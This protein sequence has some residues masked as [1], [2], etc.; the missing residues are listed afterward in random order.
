MIDPGVEGEA[1]T[2]EPVQAGQEEA[3]GERWASRLVMFL[4]LMAVVALVL[5]FFTKPV[6]YLPHCVLG[7][8]VFMIAIRLINLRSLADIRP[9]SPGEFALAITTASVV[10]VA[11]V[12]QGILLAIV[13]SLLRVVQHNY[14][15][16][17]GVGPQFK[18]GKHMGRRYQSGYLRRSQRKAGPDR[19]EY[20]WRE[21][22]SQGRVV[23]HKTI[24][25][26]VEE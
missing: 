14:H 16:H 11:G 17:T 24:V 8:L 2:L 9:E 5:L 23:R 18:E 1:N 7:A 26:T 22:N 4:R 3:S 6:A 10:V 15:P 19:W 13:L 12:E 21:I 20:L 25:G